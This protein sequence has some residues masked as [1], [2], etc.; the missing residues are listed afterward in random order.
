MDYLNFINVFLCGS[1]PDLVSVITGN[2]WFDAGLIESEFYI[3]FKLTISGYE[4]VNFL[5]SGMG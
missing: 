1:G 2:N 5:E 3:G 4:R